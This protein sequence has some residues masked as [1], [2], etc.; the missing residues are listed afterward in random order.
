MTAENVN[1]KV[2]A[3]GHSLQELI[4][5]HFAQV[6]NLVSIAGKKL[7]PTNKTQDWLQLSQKSEG[8]NR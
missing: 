7:S 5:E 2:Q 3:F 1:I 6:S 4:T 8:L